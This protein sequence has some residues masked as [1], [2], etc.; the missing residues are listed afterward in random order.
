MGEPDESFTNTLQQPSMQLEVAKPS[1]LPVPVLVMGSPRASLIPNAGTKI[2]RTASC[3]RELAS[4]PN[5]H[6]AGG[7]AFSYN[8]SGVY[9]GAPTVFSGL[10]QVPQRTICTP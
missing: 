10:G 6:S 4:A 2:A 7:L 9:P 8:A 3:R 5:D 1:H